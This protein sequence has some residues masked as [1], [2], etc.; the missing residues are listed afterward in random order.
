MTL[1][2]TDQETIVNEY[3]FSVAFEGERAI[4]LGGMSRDMFT[5][6]FDEAYKN[7]LDGCTLLTPAV[8]PNIHLCQFLVPF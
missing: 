2:R 8:H 7:L 1:Y 5:A 3:P 4:D 6:F